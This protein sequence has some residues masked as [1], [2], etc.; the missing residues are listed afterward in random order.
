MRVVLDHMEDL[1]RAHEF[2]TKVDE[3]AV[4]SE[5]ANA[6]LDHGRVGDA[7][8]AYLRASDTSKWAEVIDKA[9]QV[10]AAG[11]VA[12]ARPAWFAPSCKACCP[13]NTP[14]AKQRCTPRSALGAGGRIQ[15]SG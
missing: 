4:W 9:A 15:R 11:P 12:S 8:A 2:A 5:L 6:Y 10:R 13:G 3:P 1:D 7:I 14:T